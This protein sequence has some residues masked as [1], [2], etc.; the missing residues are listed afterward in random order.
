MELNLS[1]DRLRVGDETE[2]KRFYQLYFPCFYSFAFRY[3][4]EEE[5][6]RDIVQEV[7]IAYWERHTEFSNPVSLKV[8]FYRSIRN[9]CLNILRKPTYTQ[10]TASIESLHN[11]ASTEFLEEAIIQEEVVMIVRQQIARLSP[12]EQKIIRLSLQGKSNQEIA[13]LLAI[14]I[15]TVKTHKQKAYATLR[16]Q[17]QEIR[18][19]LLLIGTV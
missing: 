6:C 9:R 14:S 18:C 19:V 3:V 4:Q 12:Q 5:T 1:T 8:F 11:T 15:N 10:E 16:A 7:F 2:L 13:D 17:L